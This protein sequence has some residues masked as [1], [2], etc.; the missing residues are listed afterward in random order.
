[1][2]GSS[3]SRHHVGSW[4]TWRAGWLPIRA[5][6]RSTKAVSLLFPQTV[7]RVT[8]VTG[9]PAFSATMAIARMRNDLVE[10][11]PVLPGDVLRMRHGE[12]AVRVA[13]ADHDQDPGGG[14]RPVDRPAVVD[15]D[16]CVLAEQVEAVLRAGAERLAAQQDDPVGPLEGPHRVGAD[17]GRR[18]GGETRSPSAPWRRPRAA[19]CSSGK[20]RRLRIDGCSWPNRPPLAIRKISAVP[21]PPRGAGDRDANRF[22][23]GHGIDPRQWKNLSVGATGPFSS[24]RIVYL[25]ADRRRSHSD[26]GVGSGR[27]VIAGVAVGGLPSACV[28]PRSPDESWMNSE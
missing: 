22:C 21:D 28:P 1:M 15:H 27:L 11:E 20:S 25:E 26:V 12:Q 6:L 4:I 16:R 3:T 2:A 18:T 14:R 9:T 13:G 7:R 5:F 24:V 8:W 17:A 23:C 10:G 19:A